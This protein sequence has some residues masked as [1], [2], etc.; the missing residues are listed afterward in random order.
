MVKLIAFLFSLVSIFPI[1]E[2]V[3]HYQYEHYEID[4]LSTKKPSKLEITDDQIQRWNVF[5]DELS[6]NGDL[7]EKEI[8]RL[9]E[10]IKIAHQDAIA[11]SDNKATIDPLTLKIIKL[12]YPEAKQPQ[13]FQSDAYSEALSQMIFQ[14]V[15]QQFE[16]N[17]KGS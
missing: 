14:K 15:K 12:S 4:N 16:E 2:A 13:H 5:V 17:K 10:L 1:C 7:S 3:T 8:A 9:K 11:L 6:Q